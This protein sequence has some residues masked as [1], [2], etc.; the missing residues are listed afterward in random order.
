MEQ[1]KESGVQPRRRHEMDLMGMLIVVGLVFF[2][3]AQIFSGTEHYVENT[4]QGVAAGIVANLILAFASMWGM[5]L[6]M[7]IAGTAIWYS[8]RKR[9]AGQFLLNRVQRLLIPFLTGMVLVVP[10]VVWL[11][12]KFHSL[13]YSGS[14]WQFLGRWFDIRFSLSAFPGFIVGAPPDRL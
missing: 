11:G 13:S 7:L 6:M 1:R 3:S 12:L 10:V 14:Y 4:Q 8:L 5:P 9:T 2:H